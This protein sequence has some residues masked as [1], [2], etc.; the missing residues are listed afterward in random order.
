M[1]KGIDLFK[2]LRTEPSANFSVCI[3]MKHT[4]QAEKAVYNNEAY[5][6]RNI[7]QLIY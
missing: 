6:G 2:N 4:Q 5:K 1:W 3:K 7:H